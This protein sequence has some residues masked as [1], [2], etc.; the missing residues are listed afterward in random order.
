MKLFIF[1]FMIFFA[2]CSIV[3][4]REPVKAPPSVV[5]LF[6]S[7]KQDL[8][9]G[10]TEQGTQKLQQILKTQKGT[11]VAD[12]SA[13]ILGHVSFKN[14]NYDEALNYYMNVVRSNIRSPRE[15]EA[16]YLAGKTLFFLERLD[17]SSSI[18]KKTLSSDN[19]SESLKKRALDLLYQVQ[20]KQSNY[21]GALESLGKLLALTLSAEERSQ[22]RAAAQT[23]LEKEMNLSQVKDLAD[24]SDSS[25]VRGFAHFFLAQN[26]ADIREFEKAA[27]H[28]K[29]V[30]NLLPNSEQAE[31]AAIFLQ[32]ME[33]RKVV[34]PKTIGV[35]LPLSGRASTVA[36]KVLRGIQLA[37]GIFGPHKS[38]YRLA[39]VDSEG[40]PDVARRQVERLV[41][42][43]HVVAIVGSLLSKTS[44]EI[45]K[46]SHEFGVP[47]IAL[48]QKLNLTQ[49]GSSVFRNGLSSN[50]L[51][52]HLVDVAMKQMGFRNFAILY[53]NDAYG[54][55]YANLFW[56]HVLAR[57][58][59]ITGAQTYKPD[60]TDF[61]GHVRRLVGT[62]YI[63]DRLGEYK[64]YV[65]EWQ[66]ENLRFLSRKSPPDDLLPP[67]VDFEAIFIPDGTK[68][69]AQIAPMLKYN[70]VSQIPMLGTN[71]WNTRAL[72][73]RV[74]RLAENT[75]FVD[76]LS[77]PPEKLKAT[78]F[79][80]EFFETFG[81]E[82]GPFEVRA[83]DSALILRRLLESGVQ[84]RGGLITQ[85]STV[86]DFPGVGGPISIDDQ[87][88]LS[89]PMSLRTV[90]NGAIREVYTGTK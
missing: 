84:T 37:L 76:S 90:Q 86:K 69:L 46:T 87:R 4:K 51:I 71:L 32:R 36:Y 33:G 31:V 39:V 23:I 79:Y 26:L 77:L 80:K 78:T 47:S 25:E 7:A 49:V 22:Y 15:A 40:N 41:M 34:D 48:S 50:T 20:T 73:S 59:Q 55:E 17:E 14:Q 10:K 21:T 83:Y 13:I 65:K 70:D 63:E 75:L 43:D 64:H 58:G 61:R 53:P 74:G 1:T 88:E 3:T 62:F 35:I 11:D 44:E 6:E 52:S 57:G 18:L 45:A 54:T 12:D 60:E 81:E 68:A 16:N 19:L 89:Q 2:G 27:D 42:E 24:D 28:Y 5:Q 8:K 67:V 30:L 85:L 38:D 29:E 72:P 66:K 56:D 82:P 9:N